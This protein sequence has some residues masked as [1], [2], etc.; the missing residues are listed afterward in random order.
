MSREHFWNRITYLFYVIRQAH[1]VNELIR[2]SCI[3]LI[4][5]LTWMLQTLVLQQF[6]DAVQEVG[7]GIQERRFLIVMLVAMGF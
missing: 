3:N 5:A 4:Y 6:F 1:I 7:S 2:Y